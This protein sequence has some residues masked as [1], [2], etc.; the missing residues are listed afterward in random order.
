MKGAMNV[1]LDNLSVIMLQIKE[2][3]ASASNASSDSAKAANDLSVRTQQAAATL[4]EL[5]A[6][7]QNINQLQ[8]EN[9]QSLTEVSGLT[10]QTMQENDKAGE[11]ML[12][13]WKP[14]TAFGKPPPKSVTSSA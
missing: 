10:Q 9:T 6:T 11:V 13:R 2:V 4:E 8:I 14:W 1:S 3:A 5:N 12:R 7:M